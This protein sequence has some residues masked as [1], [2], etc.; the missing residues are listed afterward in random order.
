MVGGSDLVTEAEPTPVLCRFPWIQLVFCIACLSMAAWTWMRYSYAWEATPR[1]FAELSDEEE[2]RWYDYFVEVNGVIR[3]KAEEPGRGT[4]VDV[5][6]AEDDRYR[7]LVFVPAGA[8]PPINE[9]AV[10]GGSVW[11][12]PRIAT[13]SRAHLRVAGG[14]MSRPRARIEDAG[15]LF[16]RGRW[17]GA[18]VAGL[19]VG[20][21][22]CFIFALYLRRWLQERRA[23][24]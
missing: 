22:G 21:M 18:S 16:V 14:A 9:S 19:V 8:A 20:A 24:T 7:A 11:F 23:T 2:L 1:Q 17:N 6:D 13:V 3:Q 5:R 15:V 10:F 12:D 4:H